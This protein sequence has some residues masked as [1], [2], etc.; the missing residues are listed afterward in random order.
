MPVDPL[1]RP[2][3]AYQYAFDWLAVQ[4]NAAAG[5]TAALTAAPFHTLELLRRLPQLP[6]LPPLPPEAA[7]AGL[8]WGLPPAQTAVPTPQLA[9]VAWLEPRRADAHQLPLLRQWLKPGGTLYLVAA[10]RLSR[11]LAEQRHGRA[12]ADSWPAAAMGTALVQAGFQC[13]SAFGL[14]G[15]AAIGWHLL[16]QICRRLG[17]LHWQDRCHYALRRAF[18]D[19]RGR[20]PFV[21][22]TCLTL[23]RLP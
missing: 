3:L 14:H 23:E 16:A 17:R 18:I 7:E 22:L 11:F 9:A 12:A 10:G 6:F 1:L 20:Q 19:P 21:A 2:G 15:P 8:S 13:R 5:P 4:L